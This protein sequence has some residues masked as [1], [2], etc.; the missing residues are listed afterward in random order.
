[1]YADEMAGIITRYISKIFYKEM[2]LNG[3]INKINDYD[4]QVIEEIHNFKPDFRTPYTYLYKPNASENEKRIIK[5]INNITIIDGGFYFDGDLF[6][7]NN[8]IGLNIEYCDDLSS[9]RKLNND[10]INKI[11]DRDY[12]LINGFYKYTEYS[13]SKKSVILTREQIFDIISENIC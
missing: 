4:Y 11:I 3:K 10:E 5:E 1:M 2:S 6:I 12:Q 8:S 13:N 9:I 7:K